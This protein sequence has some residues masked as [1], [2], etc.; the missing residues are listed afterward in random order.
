MR[1]VSW[2]V[3][4]LRAVLSR[5][6]LDWAFTGDVDVLCLQETKIQPDHVTAAMKAPPGFSRS[7]WSFCETK[8]GYSG[9]AIFVKDG[10]F[11][12]PFALKIGGGTHP[13][14]DIEGRITGVDLGA[15]VLFGVYFPNG[16][17]SDERLT[18]KHAWHDA[19]LEAVIAL[20]KTG[21]HVVVA[22]DLN[23][24]HTDLDLAKPKEWAFVSGCLPVERA[25]FDRLLSAGFVDS[26]RAEKGDLPRQFTF[27]ETRV[28]AR[29]E[30]LG[31]RID[32]VVIPRALEE[33]LVDAWISPQIFGSDHCPVGVELDV[34]AG[35]TVDLHVD[36]SDDVV[37]DGDEQ[38]DEEE[39]G[40]GSRWR[41]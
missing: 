32:Y 13:E 29:S 22:G 10:L 18:F 37:E 31:W 27:W 24:A 35:T 20:Q 33:Q 7:F 40:G 39:D 4:G 15:F 12:E 34:R 25:W 9:T 23:V 11:A 38:E 8:K 1:I 17:S 28:D 30:N 21:R 5:G 14:Y 3:N 41:R 36:S 16:G 6:D 26:F 19:F 2:N